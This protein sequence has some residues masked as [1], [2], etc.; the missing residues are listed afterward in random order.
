M[1]RLFLSIGIILGLAT[2]Q[3]D[4][5]LFARSALVDDRVVINVRVEEAFPP[6]AL[7]LIESGTSVA[8]RFTAEVAQAGGGT[9]AA[10][11]SRSLRYDL[12]SGLYEVATDSGKKSRMVDPGAAR[13]FAS[14]LPG[15][16]LCQLGEAAPGARIVVA[17]Q[18]GILDAKGQWH[19]APVLWNYLSPRIV[20]DQPALRKKEER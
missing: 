6:G 3:P 19:D 7:D 20:I 9:V 12:R 16:E 4:P 13:T 15:L 2:G 18:I 11:D 8:L 17:A 5:V 14:E 10:Y 1:R